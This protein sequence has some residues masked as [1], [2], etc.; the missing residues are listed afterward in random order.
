MSQSSSNGSASEG[1]YATNPDSSLP[2][3]TGKKRDLAAESR[4]LLALLERKLGQHISEADLSL[5]DAVV[6][7]SRVGSLDF[8][9]LLKLDSELRFDF[10]VDVTVV[11][12]LD[13]R[14]E[15]FTV[16]YHL[17]SMSSGYRLR[18]K[19]PVSE[20]DPEVDSLVELWSSANF[21]E[22][23]AW[24]MYGIVFKNHPDLRRVLLYEEF[25]GAP[26]RKDYPVQGKQPRVKLRSPEVSNTARDMLRNELVKIQKRGVAS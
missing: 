22:R 11:D 18:V 17:M 9:R 20:R 12:W 19:I 3:S 25:K 2:W 21:M 5:G 23:E 13:R 7:I 8:F 26:L 6:T 16:V 15:R 4:E 1:R 10:L 14:T 24:D